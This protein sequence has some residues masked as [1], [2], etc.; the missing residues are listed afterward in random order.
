MDKV[1]IKSTD[2]F[3]LINVLKK[4]GIK[5]DIS[6]TIKAS[7]QIE[8]RKASIFREIYVREN[9][10]TDESLNNTDSLQ[11]LDKHEDLKEKLLKCNE[12]Y[13]EIFLNLI[14]TVVENITK[15]EKEV[16]TCIAKIYFMKESEVKELEI[17]ELIEKIIGIAKSESFMRFFTLIAK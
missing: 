7:M 1:I 16:Y 12:E 10:T 13:S 6:N 5:D 2:A 17:G 14:F 11:L 3:T 9:L 8:N 15:A 4:M